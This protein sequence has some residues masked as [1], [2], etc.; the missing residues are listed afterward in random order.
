MPS[1]VQ[2]RWSQLKVYAATGAV[3]GVGATEKVAVWVPTPPS[4]SVTVKV[5]V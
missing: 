5:T 1:N 3:F 4:L 2:S